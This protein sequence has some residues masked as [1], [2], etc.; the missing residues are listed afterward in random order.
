MSY[1]FGIDQEKLKTFYDYIN[2]DKNQNDEHSIGIL[3]SYYI[4]YFKIHFP[5]I[6]YPIYVDYLIKSLACNIH[7]QENVKMQFLAKKIINICNKGY[8]L[9]E[10]KF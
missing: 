1:P 10:L 2:Y 6:Y 7:Y 5:N 4:T 8:S 9:E 3:V